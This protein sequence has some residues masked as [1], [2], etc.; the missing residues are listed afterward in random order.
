MIA[1]SPAPAIGAM[2]ARARCNIAAHFFVQH[3][4]SA[5]EAVP[6]LPDRLVVRRQF[7]HMLARGIVRE[8]ESAKYWLD[9]AAYQADADRRR[10]I[11]VPIVVALALIAAIIPLFFYRG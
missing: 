8:A 6:F 10:R 3:A 7:E 1:S 2:I 11:L 9:T 4:V 5:D